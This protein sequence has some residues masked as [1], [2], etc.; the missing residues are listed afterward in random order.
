MLEKLLLAA[1]ITFSLN[2]FVQAQVPLRNNQEG[3]YP[4][5]MDATPQILVKMRQ[6]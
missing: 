3:A 2:M 1:S 5:H 6:K 4:S